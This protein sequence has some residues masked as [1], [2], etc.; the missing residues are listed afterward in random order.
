MMSPVVY[1]RR[2]SA[3]SSVSE[4]RSLALPKPTPRF[5]YLLSGLR[6]GDKLLNYC[7]N[8]F[9]SILG[10]GGKYWPTRLTRLTA[11]WSSF[12]LCSTFWRS[13]TNMMTSL[14]IL[15]LQNRTTLAKCRLSYSWIF[16]YAKISSRLS[17]TAWLKFSFFSLFI[18]LSCYSKF[19]TNFYLISS[20][21]SIWDR[22]LLNY[23][24][25]MLMTL[26]QLMWPKWSWTQ[27]SHK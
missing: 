15:F 1:S 11:Y 26:S 17:R 24:V 13:M 9:M 14:T 23:W 12:N 20:I 5:S 6:S 27:T 18:N 25:K 19:L 4:L 2:K 8:P 7:M 21:L 16:L 22:H 10:K 3:S